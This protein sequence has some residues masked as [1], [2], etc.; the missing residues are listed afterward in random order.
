MNLERY[1]LTAIES[2]ESYEFLSEGPQGTIKKVIRYQEVEPGF[3]NLAFGD[4][5][6]ENKQINDSIRSNNA[7]RDKIP[8]T[9]AGSVVLFMR[10]HPGAILV[11]LGQT[12]AKTRLYQM[13]ISQHWE[14]IN[15]LF[16]ISG[17]RAKGWESFT[18]G[19]NYEA[20]SLKMKQ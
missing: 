3:Y 16:D 20:L 15:N 10:E 14:E 2:K 4:W 18:A 19:Q 17:Y 5:D 9:V 8:A 13:G 11:A 12:S 6:E 7:D 1:A